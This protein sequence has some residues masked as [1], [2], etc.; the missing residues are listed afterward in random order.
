[1]KCDDTKLLLMDLLYNEISEE[2]EAM[3]KDHLSECVSCREEFE[4]LKNTSG[5]MQKWEDVDPKLNLVFV[6]DKKSIFGALKDKFSF[7]PKKLAYGFALGFVTVVL[8]FSLANTEISYKDGDFS[9]KMGIFKNGAEQNQLSPEMQQALMAQVREQNAQLIN[10]LMQQSEQR[11]RQELA[12]TLAKF[13][14]EFNYQRTND[15]KLVGAGLNEIEQ[16]LY[17]QV[18]KQTNDRFNNLI[19]YINQN[20]EMN[21][22]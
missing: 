3:L 21:R 9:L 16:K 15:L 7:A 13:S 12:A 6:S 1:M 20:Q 18:E 10:Q 19:R 8:L 2:N 11:Q 5:I 4:S 22:K 17:L 14:Q